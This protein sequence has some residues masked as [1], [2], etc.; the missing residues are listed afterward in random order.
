MRLRADA[1]RIWPDL[2]APMAQGRAR[3]E[4]RVVSVAAIGGRAAAGSVVRPALMFPEVIGH[5]PHRLE[6]M[7][8][9]E[10]LGE[11]LFSTGLAPLPAHA[12]RQFRDLTALLEQAPCYRLCL[13]AEMDE[14]PCTIAEALA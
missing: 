11:M 2:S 13:G 8:P 14:L 10:A 1:A 7:A 3:G 9:A 5:G 12:A 6:R 4:K